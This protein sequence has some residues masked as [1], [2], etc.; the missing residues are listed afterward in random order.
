[1]PLE[2]LN[3][4][5]EEIDEILGKTPNKIIRWGVSVIFVIVIVI[6]IG[7]WFFKYPDTI[8]SSIE[9]TTLNPPSDIV[10]KAS[11]KLETIFVNDNEDVVAGQMIAIIENPA[12][13]DDV[14]TLIQYMDS[15]NSDYLVQDFSSSPRRLRSNMDLGELQVAYSQ[16]L[17]SYKNYKN[18]TDLNY[19]EKKLE[20]VDSQ[21]VDYNIYYR[22]KEQQK[23]TITEDLEIAARDFER[24]KNLFASSTIAEV[25]LEK[26]RSR[27]LSK[28]YLLE[29]IQTSLANIKIQISRLE[30][31]K[32]DLELQQ[33]KLEEELMTRLNENY[34]N[35]RARLDIWE[36][37]YILVAPIDGKCIFTKYWS[38]N[39]NVIEGEK[40]MTIVSTMPDKIIGK[41]LLPVRGA[42]KVKAGQKVNI[43][44]LNYPY[45]EFGVLEG[46]IKSISDIPNDD[47]YYA[48]VSFPDGMKTN[49]NIDITF[50]QNMQGSAEIITDDI[51]ILNRIFQPIKS[52]IKNR[53]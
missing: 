32:L 44:L 47:Y 21:I 5:T 29:S 37:K 53:L 13:Y 45:M 50:S 26:S 34:D 49:Y 19:H 46:V 42:G 8:I 3:I 6:I 14:N 48:E 36:K 7:S 16:F 52:V 10:A 27:Y 39:Q 38:E 9:I 33:R 31:E 30:N 35:L 25:E 2:R 12:N 41:L 4:R 28:K 51:R 18:Y 1:M 43:R 40:I 11:G 22:N 24:H 23:A 20:A 15:R 17:T